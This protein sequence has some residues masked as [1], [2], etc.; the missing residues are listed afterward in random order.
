MKSINF[1]SK[2][3]NSSQSQYQFSSFSSC[4]IFN[5]RKLISFWKWDDRKSYEE[6]V[7][8]V[9]EN[10]AQWIEWNGISLRIQN[11]FKTEFNLRRPKQMTALQKV[12]NRWTKGNIYIYKSVSIECETWKKPIVMIFFTFFFKK[13]PKH[14]S[15]KTILWKVLIENTE[16]A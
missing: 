15:W 7:L 14:E 8:F 6:E 5:Y 3:I 13:K 1:W 11:H 9:Y 4:C 2:L 10:F 16:N 12:V